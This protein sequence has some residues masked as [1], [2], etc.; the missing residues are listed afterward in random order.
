VACGVR[1]GQRDAPAV[2]PPVQAGGVALM[3]RRAFFRGILATLAT[4]ATSPVVRAFS[5]VASET[6]IAAV[7]GMM[8]IS[9]PAVEDAVGYRLYRFIGDTYELIAHVP[10]VFDEQE[11]RWC[12]SHALEGVKNGERREVKFWPYKVVVTAEKGPHGQA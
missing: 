3:N 9:W 10:A 12:L 7:Q 4:V 11:I 1:G 2:L 5:L 6:P 8:T